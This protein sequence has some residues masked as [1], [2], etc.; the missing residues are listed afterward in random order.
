[1]FFFVEQYHYMTTVSTRSFKDPSV[2]VGHAMIR[3]SFTADLH[4]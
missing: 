4:D 3:S 2:E 1:M